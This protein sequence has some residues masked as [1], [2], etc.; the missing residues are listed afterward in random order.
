MRNL[1]YFLL[2]ASIF[3]GISACGG[4]EKKNN[5]NENVP[6][7]TVQKSADFIGSWVMESDDG[8]ETYTFKKDNTLVVVAVLNDESSFIRKASW[9]EDKGIFTLK[10]DDM[11]TNQ[12]VSYVV[13]GK[14]LKLTF[15]KGTKN[16]L[17]QT[18]TKK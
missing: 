15:N 1:I 9:K 7:E 3:I 6:K 16:E 14:N 11:D 18:F 17:I 10:F 4:E 12:T 5:E 2:A 13:E 8:V